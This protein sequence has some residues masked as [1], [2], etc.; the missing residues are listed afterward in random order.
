MG[1]RFA[2]GCPDHVKRRSMTTLFDAFGDKAGEVIRLPD[3]DKEYVQCI[4]ETIP[5]WWFPLFGFL[6]D[7]K[8]K[9]I[10]AKC[11]NRAS[12]SA[13]WVLRFFR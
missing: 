3:C 13:R 12:M 5:G 10:K 2:P 4:D 6:S 9:T 1:I 11:L 8:I 7:A